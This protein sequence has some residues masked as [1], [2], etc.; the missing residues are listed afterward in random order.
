M[1]EMSKKIMVFMLSFVLLLSFTACDGGAQSG[2]EKDLFFHVDFTASSIEDSVNK[3][4]RSQTPTAVTFETDSELNKTVGVFENAGINYLVDTSKMGEAFTMEAYVNVEEQGGYGLICGTY[5][6]NDKLGVGF[7]AGVFELEGD[8]VGI[9]KSMSMFEGNGASS[10]TVGGGEYGKWQHL[11]FVHDGA[12]DYYY[13]D[14]TE[15]TEGGLQAASST[16][17]HSSAAGFRIGAYNTVP[18]FSINKMK[19]AY[20]KLYSAAASAEEVKAL[21]ENRNA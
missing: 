16:M 21:Y 3:V 5:W 15:M 12:K 11:V 17:Q 4:A 13:V 19:A 10:T 9:R 7:G 1:I 14:G 8:K 18:Q 2:L 20:V 6:F